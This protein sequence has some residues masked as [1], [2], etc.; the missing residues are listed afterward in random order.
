MRSARLLLLILGLSLTVCQAQ[1]IEKQKAKLKLFE[2]EKLTGEFASLQQKY[3]GKVLFSNAVTTREIPESSY[4]NS[5]TFGDKLSFRAFF[6]HSILNSMLLQMID[7][8]SKAKDL[9]NN[10][11][12][13]PKYLAVLYLDGNRITN[14]SY[15]ISFGDKET[16]FDLSQRGTLN[17]DQS[18]LDFGKTLYKDLKTRIELLTP[19]KHM[20]KIEYVPYFNFGTATDVEFKPV[21]SGEIEM[22]VKNQKIDLNDPEVC[23]PTAQMTDKALDA[24]ILKAFKAKGFKAEAK[25]VR[26]TSKKWNI[27][28]NEFGIILRRYVEAYIG[29]T[30]NG[31]CYYDVYN[32]NQDYDGNA[33]QSEVYLMGEGIGT[34]RERSCECLK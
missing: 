19:G 23:L 34:E 1:D 24:K 18:D 30:K 33:Y 9:N 4:I 21:A 2:E 26:I 31:K 13:F 14:T 3:A 17:D 29:Y 8:G 27:Q 6:S 32:F 12:W 28:R 20:L 10:G 7:K 25:K 11:T 22:I 5:Y 15:A 16:H